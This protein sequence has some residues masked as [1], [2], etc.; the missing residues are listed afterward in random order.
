M[1]A[2]SADLLDDLE[3]AM[4]TLLSK[5]AGSGG[6]GGL[7]AGESVAVETG[8]AYAELVRMSHAALGSYV[9]CAAAAAG[10][11]N[12]MG[13]M[14]LSVPTEVADAATNAAAGRTVDVVLHVRSAV[15]WSGNGSAT[16]EVKAGPLVG[17]SLAIPGDGGSGTALVENLTRPVR[18]TFAAPAVR[19]HR[20]CVYWDPGTGGDDASAGGQFSDK[21]ILTEEAA[22]GSVTCVTSHLSLF[23][24]QVIP[25]AHTLTHADTSENK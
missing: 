15:P 22:N 24:L 12:Q 17:L 6:A 3:P 25:Y 8:G 10:R 11:C 14:G 13:L 4:V 1:A 21:G 7:V 23:A 19:V 18:I 16:A 20:K 2:A 5:W 9:P